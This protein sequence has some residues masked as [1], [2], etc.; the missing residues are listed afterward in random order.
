L[1]VTAQDHLLTRLDRAFASRAPRVNAG[2]IALLLDGERTL[3]VATS[4]QGVVQISSDARRSDD[5]LTHLAQVKPCGANLDIR[6]LY[7]DREGNVWAG[8]S[9]GLT[10]F[11]RSLVQGLPHSDKAPKRQVRVVAS[12][13]D[14]STWLGTDDGLYQWNGKEY[15][16]YDTTDGLQDDGITALHVDAHDGVWAA[17]RK[18]GIDRLISG[19]FK[20]VLPWQRAGGAVNAFTTDKSGGLWFA[21]NFGR[22]IQWKGGI[23]TQIELPG[24][25]DRN[26]NT[27]ALTDRSGRIWMGFENGV[28]VTYADGLTTSYTEK[29]G[30][31]GRRVTTI[32]EDRNGSIWVGTSSGVS[33][34]GKGRFLT[35]PS[36]SVVGI[37]ED[38]VGHFWI[39][40]RDGIYQYD[41]KE[42]DKDLDQ[43][44]LR[45]YVTFDMADG[46]PGAPA[47][48]G[49]PASVANQRGSV[50]FMTTNGL[51][52]VDVYSQISR[53][54]TPIKIEN[55]TMDGQPL[56][57]S[58]HVRLPPHPS[59]LQIDYTALTLTAPG[60]LR[61]R[62]RLEGFDKEWVNAGTRRQAFY[63]NLPS[64]H[65]RFRVTGGRRV[66]SDREAVWDF[67]IA[68][69]FYETITF[70]TLCAAAL[71][72]L[73][74]FAWRLRVRQLQAQA[75][76]VLGERA[77]ISRDIHDT[78]LQSL[79]SVAVRSGALADSLS[80]GTEIVRQ[81]LM[82]MRRDVEGCIRDARES[83]WNLRSVRAG[84]GSFVKELRDVT[85]DLV[86]NVPVSF[87][88]KVSGTPCPYPARTEQALLRIGQEAVANAL[89]HA[90]ASE[91]QLEICYEAD[92]VFLRVLD[93]GRG[94]D[95]NK[96]R[97]EA[98]G[99]YGL[100]IMRERARQI[101][102]TF[103]L[104]THVGSGTN[105]TVTVRESNAE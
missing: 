91:I 94:F 88:F 82:D 71:A 60:Q 13:V 28:V 53:T 6:S 102:A 99:H 32:F 41:P 12:T 92:A 11:S 87:A 76:L 9:N 66:L 10:R 57:P 14:G 95:S 69:A 85:T 33:R 44:G 35:R 84:R 59:S 27:A 72:A 5:P 1:W 101:G 30:L 43:S 54:P 19:R 36:Q 58:P 40:A 80:S 70:W 90:G 55:V 77:R 4:T 56:E 38:E 51:A 86:G 100:S 48:F 83:V 50:L 67:E 23:E 26:G 63:T 20:N 65:Y 47:W 45:R 97:F 103:E 78:L 52:I 3:W 61:F 16:R 79:A 22:L 34:Y 37:T 29:D 68:S 62:Y 31:L 17:T 64:G 74:L 93:N 7:A 105:V 21:N 2:G 8:S 25:A 24:A 15:L 49:Q 39:S 42:F 96:G 18:G 89:R 75:A 98:A 73:S 81:H 46:L 104:N